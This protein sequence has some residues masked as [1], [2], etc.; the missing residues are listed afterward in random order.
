MDELS[1]F[2]EKTLDEIFDADFDIF[3]MLRFKIS[4]C[5]IKIFAQFFFAL[6]LNFG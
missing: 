2:R 5:F 3:L 1:N 4:N 6:C